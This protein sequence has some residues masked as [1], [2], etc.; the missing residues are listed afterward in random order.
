MGGGMST[1]LQN[2]RHAARSLLKAP[3]FTWSTVLLVGLGVGAVTTVFTVV[4]HVLLRPLPY[5]EQ[6][7]LVYLTNGSHA[8]PT[9]RGLEDI[10]AFEVWTASSGADVNL[11][12]SSADPLRLRA[13]E[14]TPSFFQ[15]FGARP[16]LGRALIEDD[17]TSSQVAVL[18]HESWTTIWGADPG[19]V[20]RTIRIDGGPIEVVGVLAEGWV[21]PEGMG[22]VNADYFRPM[23]WDDPAL[24]EP[25][26]HAHQVA[27][28]LS[29]GTT[30]ATA[31]AQV[32][33]LAESVRSQFPDYYDGREAPSWPLQNFQERATEDVSQGL[34]LLLGAVGLLLLVACTNVAHLF[35][36]RGISRGKEMAVRRALGA[37]TWK[38]ASQLLAESLT[39]GLLGGAVGIALARLGLTGFERWMADLP[40]GGAISLDLR[41]LL[42]SIGLASLTA[43]LFGMVPALRT[44]SK[45]INET[46][47]ATG[48]G[49]SGTR[50]VRLLQS[51]LVVGEVS[52]S[53]VLVAVAGLLTRSFFEV[54]SEEPGYDIESVWMLPLNPTGIQSPDEYRTRMGAVR[55]ALAAVPGVSAVDYGMEAPFEFTGGASCCWTASIALTEDESQDYQ[56]NVHTVTE[57]F[58]DTYGIELIAGEGWTEQEARESSVPLVISEQLAI[59]AFGSA[60]AALRQNLTMGR[61]SMAVRGVA[62]ATKHYGLDQDHEWAVYA[63]IEVLPFPIDRV[64]FGIR[65]AS[66]GAGFSRLVREAVWTVEGDLPIPTV[67]PFEAWVEESSAG[68]RFGSLLFGAFGVLALTLAAAG[69]YGTILYSVSQQR[70]EIGIRLALGASRARIQ[71]DIVRKGLTL[72]LVGIALGGAGA[73]LF[74]TYLESQL[75]GVTG[76]DPI[77]LTTAAT[78][79]FLTAAVAS[80]LPAWKA[81]RTDPLETLQA[82]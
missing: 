10:E 40:G 62:Q 77:A 21:R 36:A 30:I 69:L 53:L 75:Y 55:E 50:R 52:I 38:L 22:G 70:K 7:R 48:R 34:Y 2:F 76:T 51:S 64:T 31:D 49:A 78:T 47:R 42:F 80:W 82:E 23:N 27:A 29:T 18:T 72:S 20:G 24:Q 32:A 37:G 56:V 28:R 68:R 25:G 67:E 54:T 11:S 39:I 57:S 41:V 14:V 17:Y 9:L 45:D 44:V 58:F 1:L 81:S 79:L 61:G 35:M 19:I 59:A 5:P 26:Y 71:Q 63:P 12:R 33:L 15:L 43:L 3:T 60:E 66:A 74:G 46:L 65:A 13:I 8:G 4:D 16:H 6:E 73:L